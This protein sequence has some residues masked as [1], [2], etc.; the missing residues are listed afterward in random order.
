MDKKDDNEDIEF[1]NKQKQEG[2]FISP[3]PISG[4][5]QPC[6]LVEKPVVN[7]VSES[8]VKTDMNQEEVKIVGNERRKRS[9]VKHQ[10][11]KPKIKDSDTRHNVKKPE[12]KIQPKPEAKIN[13]KYNYA[14]NVPCSRA[15]LGVRYP[16][17]PT[18]TLSE[19]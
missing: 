9:E 4:K 15:K 6:D 1:L 19:K 8:K 12:A 7:K 17:L 3:K 2:K 18:F 5:R 16:R 11:P 14:K 13:P 10:E